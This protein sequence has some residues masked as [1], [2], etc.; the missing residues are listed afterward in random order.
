M[1]IIHLNITIQIDHYVFRVFYVFNKLCKNYVFF[2]YIYT[3]PFMHLHLHTYAHTLTYL[4]T[5]IYLFIYT[6]TY[7]ESIQI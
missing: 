7:K 3:H 2:M 5:L 1:N 4:H 6:Y